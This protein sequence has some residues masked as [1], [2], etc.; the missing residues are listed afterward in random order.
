MTEQATVRNEFARVENCLFHALG[1]LFVVV[2]NERPNLENIG[3]REWR[4]RICVHCL[5]A[6]S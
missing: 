4:E 6:R 5:G 1:R 3:F 2:G